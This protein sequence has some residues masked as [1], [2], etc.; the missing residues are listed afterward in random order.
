MQISF[1]RQPRHVDAST[2]GGAVVSRLHRFMHWSHLHRLLILGLL[3]VLQFGCRGQNEPDAA[4]GNPSGAAPTSNSNADDSGSAAQ[5]A[6]PKGDEGLAEPA[7]GDLPEGTAEELFEYLAKL[8]E[9]ALAPAEAKGES[10]A[11]AEDQGAKL[12]ELMRKR[13]AISDRIMSKQVPDETQLRALRVKLDAL[14]TLAALDASRYRTVFAELV[15]QLTK[16]G[17]PLVARMARCTRW[18][19][20]VTDYLSLDPAKAKPEDLTAA[21]TSVIQQLDSLLADPEAGPETLDAARNAMGWIFEAGNV[22]LAAEGY[23]KIGEKFQAA[24]EEAVATEGRSLL[25]QAMRLELTQLSR[26]VMDQ[27]EGALPAMLDGLDRLMKPEQLDPNVLGYAIQTAEFLEFTGHPAESLQAYEKIL[28]RFANNPDATVVST[29]QRTVELARRRLGLIGS[30]A[31]LEGVTLGG[32]AFDWNS[33]RGKWVLVGFWTTWQVNARE[34]I[35]RLREAVRARSADNLEVVLVNLDDDRNALERFLKESPIG[36][37]VLVQPDP[38]AAGFENP[39][40]VRCGVETVP[41]VMLVNPEG[42]VADIHLIGDRLKAA[43]DRI[44]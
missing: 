41:F 1:R 35:D 10:Q 39:N 25:S 28:T 15:E 6:A 21:S 2:R 4:A 22:D 3:L 9:T 24:S 29:I 44:Q 31:T 8:E 43:L 32:E 30:D 13:I 27:R 11:A 7:L 34:E 20:G 19:S 38:A 33:F 16:G 17:N 42:K 26:Q 12:R 18:Q 14:R 36:W 5:S 23:R 37:K 40:A